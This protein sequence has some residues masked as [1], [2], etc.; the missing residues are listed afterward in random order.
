MSTTREYDA[1]NVVCIAACDSDRNSPP[2]SMGGS[3]CEVADL[4]QRLES[5]AEDLAED[6]CDTVDLSYYSNSQRY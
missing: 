6:S 4:E 5:D 3:S 2:C 1:Y